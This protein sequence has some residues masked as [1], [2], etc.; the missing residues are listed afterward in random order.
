[1]DIDETIQLLQNS[2]ATCGVKRFQWYPVEWNQDLALAIANKMTQLKWFTGS[3]C[4][5]EHRAIF[6]AKCV[7]RG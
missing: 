3:G 6:E 1:M 4:P 5:K 2:A 7:F